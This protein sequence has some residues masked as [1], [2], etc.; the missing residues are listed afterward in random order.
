ML[1]DS[2][3]YDAKRQENEAWLH[4][5]ESRLDRMATPAY[6]ADVLES[7]LREQRVGFFLAHF[8]ILYTPHMLFNPPC[9][10][11]GLLL[12]KPIISKLC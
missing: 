9:V 1:G 2:Q 5:M 12:N 3:K 7:Q 4:R 10:E 11:K 6:T 8:H